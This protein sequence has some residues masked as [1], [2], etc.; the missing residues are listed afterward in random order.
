MLID[1]TFLPV[2][3]IP[4]YW[5]F[6][7]EAKSYELKL[8]ISPFLHRFSCDP[9]CTL[10]E[11]LLLYSCLLLPFTNLNFYY[12]CDVLSF[13]R[14]V[15]DDSFLVRYWVNRFPTFRDSVVISDFSFLEEE[16]IMLFRNAG[17]LLPSDAA[18]YS[19]RRQSLSLANM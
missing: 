14:I 13:L 4:W 7:A 19:R 5:W 10:L 17:N 16:G 3:S 11:S 8:P 12:P 18:S 6:V 9:T 15:A 2:I 1:Y